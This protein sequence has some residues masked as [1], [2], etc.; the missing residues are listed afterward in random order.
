MVFKY[1][2]FS[3]GWEWQNA[4]E[5]YN[6][7]FENRLISKLDRL[8][9]S[10]G[11]FIYRS[12]ELNKPIKLVVTEDGADYYKRKKVLYSF[13]V[14][15]DATLQPTQDKQLLSS[16][17]QTFLGFTQN[18][19]YFFS[20]DL[21]DTDTLSLIVLCYS[22]ILPVEHTKNVV[23][24]NSKY[25][26]TQQIVL[27][28]ST[29]ITPKYSNNI[30]QERL[31]KI[32]KT[33]NAIKGLIDHSPIEKYS[34]AVY[35][36]LT[37]LKSITELVSNSNDIS[38]LL[39]SLNVIMEHDIVQ[40]E[41]KHLI[42]VDVLNYIL[43]N[44]YNV[45]DYSKLI[46]PMFSEHLDEFF[47][48][49]SETK[50]YQ[51]RLT[52]EV[53][54]SLVKV[55][56]ELK[57]CLTFKK[58]YTNLLI[59]TIIKEP[60]K[61]VYIKQYT[62]NLSTYDKDLVDRIYNVYTEYNTAYKY[63]NAPLNDILTICNTDPKTKETMLVSL[64]DRLF[65]NAKEMLSTFESLTS[66]EK[67]IILDDL[68]IQVDYLERFKRSSNIKVKSILLVLDK[69]WNGMNFK[70]TKWLLN[71][72]NDFCKDTKGV[73]ST[74]RGGTYIYTNVPIW[75]RYLVYHV[76]NDNAIVFKAV[77][78]AMLEET[79]KATQLLLVK[80][81]NGDVTYSNVSDTEVKSNS[82]MGVFRGMKKSEREEVPNS[83][84]QDYPI[85]IQRLLKS[86]GINP[87][88]EL[89]YSNILEL[90][91]VVVSSPKEYDG[92]FD[93]VVKYTETSLYSFLNVLSPINLRDKN[94]NLIKYN[95]TTRL[96]NSGVDLTTS[97]Y[98]QYILFS[99]ANV[100]ELC[101][102]LIVGM[103]LT[104]EDFKDLT[105]N[106]TILY[107]TEDIEV[108]SLKY[109]KTYYPQNT[110]HNKAIFN[111]IK[112]LTRELK[113]QYDEQLKVLTDGSKGE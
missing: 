42:V 109:I 51:Y 15:E 90:W 1:G 26:N 20:T 102:K 55:P 8:D 78:L 81:L 61:V 69:F 71:R 83:V 74:V 34:L 72:F 5:D 103:S 85:S 107:L 80:P 2:I 99:D 59:A 31:L 76:S 16:L 93:E 52:M 33:Y 94:S 113:L 43:N 18:N 92:L 105:K 7:E 21:N 73:E 60:N 66:S 75:Y 36:S 95:F 84:L 14:L 58:M 56:V 3:D 11:T 46:L 87:T 63:I 30:T 9:V 10:Q 19:V 97:K 38:K 12:E 62:T 98:F 25:I 41:P 23:Y 17:I 67:G 108:L 22:G 44:H 111:Y 101:L 77:T 57:D 49:V 4:P 24:T 6:L 96:S 54:K 53:Y 40:G 50:D 29:L 104:F 32:L 47:N 82:I 13:E 27:D 65:K 88:L 112:S 64:Y 110:E 86:K 79:L 48:R 35:I 37:G 106:Y 68:A 45:W 28:R 89:N 91:K 39:H 100:Q 70:T